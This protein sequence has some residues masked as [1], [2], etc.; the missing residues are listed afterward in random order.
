MTENQKILRDDDIEKARAWRIEHIDHVIRMIE[1]AKLAYPPSGSDCR[2]PALWKN[3]HW[4]W[5]VD[6]G[7]GRQPNDQQPSPHE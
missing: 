1:K 6:N 7:Y 4:K 5:F 2:N 3:E